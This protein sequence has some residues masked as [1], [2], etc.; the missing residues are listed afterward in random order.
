MG[1]R[2]AGSESRLV[3]VE[4]DGAAFFL[5]ESYEIIIG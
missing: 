3:S 4:A 2:R 5:A 1:Y